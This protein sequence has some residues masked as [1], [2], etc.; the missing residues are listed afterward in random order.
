MHEDHHDDGALS[1]RR[2]LIGA[3]F[4]AGVGMGTPVLAANE[5]PPMTADAALQKLKAGNEAYVR[6]MTTTRLQTIEERAA[7]GQGQAPFASVL[8]CADSRTTPEIIF[9]QG[10]GDIFVVRVAGNVAT[11]TERAS[12]EYASAVLKSPLIVVMGHSECGAVKAAID[13]TKGQTFPGDIQTL[14]T[15]IEPAAQRTKSQSG[16]W[17]VNAIKENVRLSVQKLRSSPVLGGLAESGTL[18][19]VGAYYKLETGEVAFLDG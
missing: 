14:A 5:A 3:A 19:I 12:L 8:S 15:L 17:T 13:L 6:H 7:L 1:R 16:D 11:E 2:F 18:Q 10:L 9:N 4:A